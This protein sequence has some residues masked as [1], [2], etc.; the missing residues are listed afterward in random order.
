[1]DSVTLAKE[2][3]KVCRLFRETVRREYEARSAQADKIKNARAAISAFT[4]LETAQIREEK[5]IDD[6]ENLLYY[7]SSTNSK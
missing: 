4:R 2:G 5:I 7:Y 6:F 1:M 3:R